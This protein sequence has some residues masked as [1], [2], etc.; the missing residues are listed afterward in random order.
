MDL[1]CKWN[2]NADS[3]YN[4]YAH[5]FA[6]IRWIDLSWTYLA[7]VRTTYISV[8]LLRIF[9]MSFASQID[10]NLIVTYIFL[11]FRKKKSVFNLLV[12]RQFLQILKSR[13]G[14]GMT[15]IYSTWY[16]EY[17]NSPLI[18]SPYAFE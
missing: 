12:C 6:A 8:H 13:T 7:P 17:N 16:T 10:R 4:N 11:F 14:E 15:V 5:V 9:L 3:T 2:D 18:F 1:T